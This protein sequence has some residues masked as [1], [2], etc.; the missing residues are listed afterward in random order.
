MLRTTL[1]AV[2]AAAAFGFATSSDALARG[3]HGGGGGMHFGGG[4]HAMS[5]AHHNVHFAFDHDRFRRF[6]RDRFHDRRF[7]FDHD[8]F[9]RFD[10]FRH[11]HFAFIGAPYFDDYDNG[12]DDGCYRRRPVSTSIGWVWR[13][14]NV[15]Y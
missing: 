11:R 9:D 4:M 3:G 10:R 6:D 8:R 7:A 1:I 2:A 12:Y 5:F 13:T 15:C 14:V